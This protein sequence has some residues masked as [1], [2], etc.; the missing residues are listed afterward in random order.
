[1]PK[2]T[3]KVQR[4]GA[5]MRAAPAAPFIP[6]L[7]MTVAKRTRVARSVST[8][9]PVTT[10][11]ALSRPAVGGSGENVNVTVA[12]PTI[13]VIEAARAGDAKSVSTAN[14]ARNTKDVRA[15]L[16]MVN[17]MNVSAR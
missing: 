16:L 1:M 13:F 12:A 5:I 9:T 15:F 14:V 17:D 4:P 7:G 2:A 11:V 6:M 8:G 10:T 3:S